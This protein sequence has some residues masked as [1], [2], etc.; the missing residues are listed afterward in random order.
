M[1]R[2]Q[3]TE[4]KISLFCG[5]WEICFTLKYFSSSSSEK[6]V[7]R[8]WPG[9]KDVQLRFGSLYFVGIFFFIVIEPGGASSIPGAGGIPNIGGG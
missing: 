7:P 1:F 5:G 4:K 3:L 8:T 6:T 2:N 9:F